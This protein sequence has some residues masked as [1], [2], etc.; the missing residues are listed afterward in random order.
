MVQ[1]RRLQRRNFSFEITLKGILKVANS[2]S[3]NQ[4]N[5]RGFGEHQVK[6]KVVLRF[7]IK[8]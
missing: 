1:E 4:T 6:L 8:V 7:L 2:T 5:L 3:A